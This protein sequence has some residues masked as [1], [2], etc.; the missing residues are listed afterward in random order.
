MQLFFQK[1]PESYS[2][3]EDSRIPVIIIHGLFG[4]TVNWRSFAKQLSKYCPVIVVDQRN[5]GRSAHAKSHTYIDMASDLLKLFDSLGLSMVQLCGHSMGGKAAM[6]FALRNPERVERMAVLDIA[7]VEY[8]HTHAPHLEK[9]IELDLSALE[10]RSAADKQ[11]SD[12]ITDTST[13]L[14][15]LQSLVGSKGNFSW[16]LN[17]PVLLANMSKILGFPSLEFDGL[18]YDS[19][20]LF[21]HGE[22]SDYVKA[23]DYNLILNYFPLADFSVI[24]HAGHWLHAEQPQAVLAALLKLVKK[25]TDL[26]NE[27]DQEQVNY[28]MMDK[29]RKYALLIEA[30][31][32]DLYKYALWLCKDKNMAE[33]VMQEAFLRAWKSLDSLREAKAAKGWLFTIFR[34]EHARQFERKQFQYKDVESMDT[35]EDNNHM[36]YDDR[37]EAFALRNALKRLPQDYREPLE[38]QVLGGFSCDEIAGILDI[39]SS[40]VMTR[41][42]RARKKMRQILGHESTPQLG[43]VGE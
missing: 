14:F 23:K 15:L 21:M 5:H 6:A 25:M 9:M 17:L 4:S 18:R 37:P 13:R 3:A 1:Y 10:S 43:V 7:P 26:S 8:T 36:G 38:M 20:V 29:K 12:D 42:F 27:S 30:H 35:I 24:P 31:S 28:N 41:L 2:P 40:A 39:S 32:K 22:Q 16:R 34:R 11:L 19:K 33:D